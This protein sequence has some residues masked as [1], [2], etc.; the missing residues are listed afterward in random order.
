MTSTP[1]PGL[2]PRNPH[3]LGY[4]FEALVASTPELARHLQTAPHG[5]ATIDFA[6]PA[7]VKALN[8]ALLRHHYGIQDWDIPEGYL[9]PPVP[10]RAD[11]LHRLAD[12]LA[13]ANGGELPPGKAI[14]VL[15]IG[16]GA[17]LIYPLLG[18]RAMGWRFVGT[19]VD[20][21]ALASAQR[22]LGAN[23]GLA[24][25]V[26]LRRQRDPEAIFK[27]V[28][29]PGESFDLVVCNPPFH[30][31][32][33]AAEAG[34]RRKWEN[35]RKPEPKGAPTLNFGGGAA[36]LWCPGGEVAFVGRIIAGSAG[37]KDRLLWCA[38]LVSK[39]ESLPALRSQL[40]QYGA[41][42]VRVLEMV[43]GQKRSRLLAWTFLDAAARKAWA[44]ARWAD[45]G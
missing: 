8:R 7:A 10:G 2:H 20:A 15:D 35:L 38:A 18:R 22:I 32:A 9:C 23:P 40:R 14:R 33:Q 1:K 13:E 19:D 43:Q 28:V 5:G 4:A 36:E 37:L 45:P 41:V 29:R 42:E 31:S 24:G 39:A 44:G 17:N 6:D 34:S 3:R 11:H 21:G 26:T 30:A 27:G 16:T 12:L 25:A